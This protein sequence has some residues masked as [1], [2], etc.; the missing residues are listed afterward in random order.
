MY[1][2][3]MESFVLW[4][5][6]RGSSSSDAVFRAGV[7]FSGYVLIMAISAAVLL[8]VIG[9]FPVAAWLSS[10]YWCIWILAAA[11][12]LVH[13]P[14]ARSVGRKCATAR[15][16]TPIPSPYLWVWFFLPVLAI[17]VLA[18]ALAISQVQ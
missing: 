4:L 11:I 15:S 16:R 10:N 18:V 17:F 6:S 14:L 12:A 9:G 5:Q 7:A 2:H 8:D 13:W 3:L 1:I